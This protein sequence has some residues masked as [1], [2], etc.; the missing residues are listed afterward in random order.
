MYL[1]YKYLL[2]NNGVEVD[3]LQI[4]LTTTE[5]VPFYFINYKAFIEIFD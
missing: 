1:L 3:L 4:N 5:N 2:L